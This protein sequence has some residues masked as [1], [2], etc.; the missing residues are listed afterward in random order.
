MNVKAITDKVYEKSRR[1]RD[2]VPI[3]Y[4]TS[5]EPLT[6]KKIKRE[7]VLLEVQNE[8]STF[9]YKDSVKVKIEQK[10]KEMEEEAKQQELQG[11]IVK[12]TPI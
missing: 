7:R 8:T 11:V 10:E 1:K 3:E 2:G 6:L 12:A 4:K 5:S 9:E